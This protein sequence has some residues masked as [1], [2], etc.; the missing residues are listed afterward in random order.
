MIPKMNA[1][2]S[3]WRKRDRN[4]RVKNKEFCSSTKFNEID[5]LTHTKSY[6]QQLITRIVDYIVF[7]LNLWIYI[8][9]LF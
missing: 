3:E 2:N 1:K 5:T 4:C 8:F 7:L 6:E 9:L